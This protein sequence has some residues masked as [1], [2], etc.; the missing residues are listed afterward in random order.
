MLRAAVTECLQKDPSG[1]CPCTRGYPCGAHVGSL[2]EYDTTGVTDMR[3]LF[4]EAESFNYDISSWNTASVTDMSHMFYRAYAFNQPI[5][6]WNTSSVTD[7]SHMFESEMESSFN[8]PIGEWDTS[9]VTDMNSMFQS[10]YQFNQPIGDWNTSSVT[11]MRY[12]F[13][14]AYQFNQPIGA[15]DTSSVT[16]M[17]Y[18]FANAYQFNQPI[19]AWDTSSVTD[20]GGMFNSAEKFNQPL[21]DWDVSRVSSFTHMFYYTQS[22][23]QPNIRAWNVRSDADVWEMFRYSLF[24]DRMTCPEDQSGPPSACYVTP[25]STSYALSQ[26]VAACFEENADGDCE[27]AT[28]SCGEAGLHISYW[29][30]TGIW[31]MYE[32]F[33]DRATFNQPLNWETRSVTNFERMFQGASSFNQNI[34][35]WSTSM[36]QNMSS[37]FEGASAFEK[38]ISNWIVPDSADTSDI[39]KG[40]T[41]FNAR[42]A[43][44]DVDDGPP[45]TCVRPDERFFDFSHASLSSLWSCGAPNEWST[46]QGSCTY[47]ATEGVYVL[48]NGGVLGS[49]FSIARSTFDDRL[50]VS[51]R[52]KADSSVEN[53]WIIVY[54]DPM[55]TQVVYN[56]GS[57]VLKSDYCGCSYS[58]GQPPHTSVRT[59]S[60]CIT[61][62]TNAHSERS[63]DAYI[64]SRLENIFAF[65]ATRTVTMNLTHDGASKYMSTEIDNGEAMYETKLSYESV[66][67]DCYTSGRVLIVNRP[68]NSA[69]TKIY[70]VS[71]HGD[72]N[73]CDA[74]AAPENGGIGDCTSSLA[75][76]STCQPTCDSGYT[77]SGTSSCSL[78]TLTAATCIFF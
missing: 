13:Q 18:M 52:M 60:S 48:N 28:N 15:W 55:K 42:F 40:A 44:D 74:S 62:A 46:N 12:M 16:D 32:L 25:I 23:N 75:S 7:M 36:A 10:A 8:Q 21:G 72:A 9:R 17:T 76:G 54:Y 41:A 64:V 35:T 67:E 49:T 69:T 47:D 63:T 68:L 66:N 37:M 24:A 58:G 1:A 51:V 5:G 59:N 31:R 29:N 2:S 3:E 73:P 22:F 30:T 53:I 4:K 14:S 65:D 20:M 19:G 38:D 33:K 34:S 43:C 26:A 71:I 11:V 61:G 77:V 27:C 45:N 56:E 78:G 50:K 57:G 39:F 6:E 70:S